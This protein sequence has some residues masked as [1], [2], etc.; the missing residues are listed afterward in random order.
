LT[1][2]DR[3]IAC[4][5][6]KS[7]IFLV[8]SLPNAKRAV[9]LLLQR[10]ELGPHGHPKFLFHSRCHHLAGLVRAL[11]FI[12]EHDAVDPSLEQHPRLLLAPGRGH[13]CEFGEGGVVGLLRLERVSDQVGNPGRALPDSDLLEVFLGRLLPEDHLH[14]AEIAFLPVASA[15]RLVT[16]SA[17]AFGEADD[18]AVD[19]EP[20]RIE[21]LSFGVVE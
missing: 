3:Q 11:S 7:H 19:P 16:D 10:G 4:S 6:S 9:L 13:C 8:Q 2:N 5:S 1:I 15:P 14:L 12:L 18:A 20:G 21:A 17:V